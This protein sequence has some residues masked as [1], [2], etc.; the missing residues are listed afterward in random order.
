MGLIHRT[1]ALLL[2]TSALSGVAY[3]Q[4]APTLV[5]NTVVQPDFVSGLFGGKIDVYNG[6]ATNLNSTNGT[7]SS[8]SL[9]GTPTAPTA[10]SGT[11]TTQVAT[12]A[13]VANAAG[14][15]GNAQPCEND[16]VAGTEAMSFASK[17]EVSCYNLTLG[18]ANPT[19]TISGGS[20]GA[21]QRIVVIVKEPAGTGYPWTLPT[22]STGNVFVLGNVVPITTPGGVT[23]FSAST[24]DGGL[25]TYI[26]GGSG[27]TTAPTTSSALTLALDTPAQ[28]TPNTSVILT[29]VYTGVPQSLDYNLGAG[30]VQAVNPTFINGVF[31]I[32]TIGGVG[33][34]TYIPQVRDHYTTAVSASAGTMVASAWTPSTLATSPGAAA[35]WEFNA[36]NPTAV[37]A[38]SDSSVNLVQNSLNNTQSLAA[39]SGTAGNKV[40][41]AHA[42]GSDARRRVL[43]FHATNLAAG[44]V[45][46]ASNWLGAGG[47]T[48][49]AG[50]SLVNLANST[51]LNANGSFTAVIGM[52]IDAAFTLQAGPAWGAI[53]PLQYD[54][55]L[56]DTAGGTMGA[57]LMSAAGTKT[58]AQATTVPVGWHVVTESKS[59]ATLTYRLD[60]VQV[61][62]AVV[63]TSGTFTASDF[64]IGGGFASG[65]NQENG[66]PPPFIGEFQA[67]SGALA[68]TDLANAETLAGNAIGLSL[69][70]VVPA[71]LTFASTLSITA[72]VAVITGAAFTISGG[73]IGGPPLA[74]DAALDGGS[75][76]PVVSPSI[77]STNSTYAFAEAAIATAGTH[78]IQVRDHYAPTVVS[79]I[80]P[81]TVT[82]PASSGVTSMAF[83][84]PPTTCVA[85]QACSFSGTYVGSGAT[86]VDY[87]LDTL[88]WGMPTNISY[89]NN[90][91]SFVMPVGNLAGVGSHTLQVRDDINHNALAQV[92]FIENASSVTS[93]SATAL[94]VDTPAQTQ[95]NTAFTMTGTF[96]GGQ[97]QALDWSTDGNT[98]TAAA[99]PTIATGTAGSFSFNVAAGIA[100][101]GSYTLRVRD[102]NSQLVI[103]SSGNFVVNAFNPS[104][105]STSPGASFVWGFDANNQS[106]VPA[107]ADGSISQVFNSKPGSGAQYLTAK[108]GA[109]AVKI[110]ATRQ[111]GA[112][113]GHRVIDFSPSTSV[114]YGNGDPTTNWLAAGATAGTALVQLSNATNLSTG[115]AFTAI[116][117]VRMDTTYTFETMFAW[118]SPTSP[119]P[120]NVNRI[121]WKNTSNALGVQIYGNAGDMA[122]TGGT[123]STGW[124]VLSELKDA[125]GNITY[126]AN[127]AVIG[128]TTVGMTDAFTASDFLIGGDFG[129]S[130]STSPSIEYGVP[131]P[132]VGALQTY[133]GVLAGTDLS[134]AEH[135]VGSSIGLTW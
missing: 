107:A 19:M 92:T 124:M 49:N 81:F 26:T 104:V 65:G 13:F 57:Q 87:Q 8:P 31:T 67:Y 122:A 33:A 56:A 18:Q 2:A 112:D 15:G 61:A 66:N 83:N 116:E 63:A 80:T 37:A 40:L 128:Q 93:T 50:S 123:G 78:T 25:N 117:A 108:L 121:R 89:A 91:F 85:Y 22:S 73:F 45:D 28:T 4:R 34:G 132:Y 42:S 103:A 58:T 131:P 51:N 44:S 99:S 11:A 76:I 52:K 115:G 134:S 129:G 102:H 36:S 20:P 114:N 39:E 74:L 71:Q 130:T 133:S 27:S 90:Q 29:G 100:T 96:S 21:Y 60:G 5:P 75:Y 53:S 41:V 32:T 54:Q 10:S 111:S 62:Q 77:A 125:S 106:L 68:G 43:Q 46:P 135:M 97:P 3:A 47:T 94:L 119:G 118:G 120:Y 30:W 70:P 7:F 84:P 38:A 23:Q 86:T 12:T 69:N 14:A 35:V 79:P 55:I 6:S 110:V 59:G 24:Y 1:G 9:T 101:A 88:G 95:P 105:L 72:P 48:G 82:A 113:A 126:R 16:T 64:L 98:W 127:G 17:V 109:S